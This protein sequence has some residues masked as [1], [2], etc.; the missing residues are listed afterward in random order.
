MRRLFAAGLTALL[1]S[2]A[3]ALEPR[4]AAPA[5]D[6]VAVAEAAQRVVVGRI[7]P[8]GAPDASG[9]VASLTVEQVVAGAGARGEQWLVVWEELAASRPARFAEGDRVLLALVPGPRS[10]LWRTRVPDAQ[11]LAAAWTPAADGAGFLSEPSS[12]AVTLLI[13]YLALDPASRR[14]PTGTRH[15]LALA[16][17]AE[18]PLA[19]AAARRL[20]DADG[21]PLDAEVAALA[22]RALSRT[23]AGEGFEAALVAWAAAVQ[24]PG[25]AAAL[26]ARLAASPDPALAGSATVASAPPAVWEARAVLAGGLPH[27][28]IERL[29]DDPKPARRRSGI[30]AAGPEEAAALERVARDDRVP[31]LRGEAVARRLGFAD[32]RAVDAG[33]DALADPD[34]GVRA[35][36]AHGLAAKGDAAVPRLHDVAARWEAPANA[37]AVVALRLAGTAE[38]RAALEALSVEHEDP[39]VRALARVAL[40]GGLEEPH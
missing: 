2:A 36:A 38:A 32:A 22:V 27:D 4:P 37:G 8:V 40:G 39:G 3:V 26:D 12:G 11:R 15:L 20:R 33:I 17:G 1:A 7:G 10:S 25:L 21:A 18:P 16:E 9:R 14:G 30:R 13:H 35:R 24:P 6:L 23:D 5:A 31:E 29:L 28:D 34:A 19:R